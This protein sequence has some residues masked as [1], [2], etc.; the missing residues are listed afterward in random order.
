MPFATKFKTVHCLLLLIALSGNLLAQWDWE[1]KGIP[2]TREEMRNRAER[3][4]LKDNDRPIFRYFEDYLVEENGTVD[5]NL[6][7]MNGD[8]T[9]RG[10]VN[11]DILVVFG[12]VY[13][14]SNAV[15]TGN[16]TS[17][18][19]EIKQFRNSVVSGNQIETSPR[20]LYRHVNFEYDGSDWQWSRSNN[21]ST[22]P[23]W[24]LEDRVLFDYN[25]VQGIFLGLELPK[26]IASKARIVTVHGFA[27]YGFKEKALRYSLGLDRYFFNRRD[28]RFEIGGKFYDLTDTH[29]NWIIMPS[30]NMLSSIL[31]H[32]D[33]RD[34]Y[35]RRGYELHMSQNYTVFLKGTLGYRSDDYTSLNKNADWAIFGGDKKFR[36]NPAI[37]E[38]NMRSIFA[39]IYW[40]SRDDRELPR[41]G[42][43]AKLT[44]EFSNSK[45]K[46]D[47]FFNRYFFEFRR[48][49]PLSHSERL[50]IRLIAATAEGN[51]PIQKQYELGGLSTLRGFRYKEF[52]GDR[53]LLGNFEYNISPSTFSRDL[54]FFDDV[55]LIL[56]Y[57]IGLAWR[58]G[59][60]SK[61][62]KGFEFL[63]F[64]S[65][66]SDIGIALSD[67]QGQIRLNIAKRT[68]T[69]S[70]PLE[71]TFRISKPF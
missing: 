50:D 62:S 2:V 57:D 41:R 8:V 3:K 12:D 19:G 47:F 59:D 65:L 43:Y 45:L 46:S 11:G 55:R 70:R 15:V 44:A 64:N 49:Q 31:I 48:Y 30:E 42:W 1:D 67:W 20:N 4:Y 7:V 36:A 69:N 33:F 54:L 63:K 6:V 52:A 53:M 32:E 34:Y 24:P 51:L 23:L 66:K 22:L 40:D 68:D 17:V 56:F 29:D 9:I 39:E 60:N 13:V 26:S 61:W 58:S 25:R 10:E 71:V 35:R 5:G 38:G 16:I 21:Y 18:G 14:H 27:G 37:V 28:Y